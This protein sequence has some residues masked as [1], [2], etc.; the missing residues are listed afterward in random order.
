[1]CASLATS[2]KV[3]DPSITIFRASLSKPRSVKGMINTSS[4]HWTCVEISSYFAEVNWIIFP[5]VE[6]KGRT[7]GA[8]SAL[9]DSNKVL[10]MQTTSETNFLDSDLST[11]VPH[12]MPVL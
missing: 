8:H 1:M 6:R 11:C 10:K 3:H 7:A 12:Q 2:S 9:S 5:V 4:P